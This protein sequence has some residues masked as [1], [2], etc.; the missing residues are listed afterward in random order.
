MLSLRE[1][2]NLLNAELIGD[3]QARFAAVNSDSRS[4]KSGDLFVA[5]PGEQFDGHDFI[6]KAVEQGASAVLAQRLPNGFKGNALL[7][8]DTY[9]ALAQLARAWRERFQLP[10]IA[11]TGSNGKTTVKEMIAAVLHAAYGCDAQ[12]QTAYLATPG[13]LNNHIGV[14]LT[15]L[16]L[17][18]THRAAVIE[19]GMNHPGEIA[20][21][22][23]L[24]QPTV[25]L[26]NNAQREHQE[27]MQSVAAVAQENGSVFGALPTDGVAVFP[28]N[29]EFDVLWR[30]LAAP[31]RCVTF[32]LQKSSAQL[33]PNT[34]G[35]HN[36]RNAEAAAACC[37]AIGINEATI[38]QGLASFTPVKGRL[39][40]QR[41]ANGSTLIDDSY[42]ANPD[43]VRAA[44]DV[45]ASCIAPTALV[46]GDMGEV[47]EDNSAAFHTEV[48]AY[49]KQRGIHYL[50]ALGSAMSASCTAFGA[51]AQHFASVETLVKVLRALPVTTVLV[52]GSR[53]MRMERV[54]QGLSEN[55]V[56]TQSTH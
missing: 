4:L 21:L 49:A 46:L 54:V 39:V 34:L 37:R 6:Q 26:V 40:V 31:R 32:Q 36:A 25:A 7:V 3:G 1:A 11:V 23:Q 55:F 8:P 17:R 38:A 19:L 16:K 51:G 52:K 47:G 18:D 2:A 53:F 56:S 28:A 13:N 42:N 43:S 35:E 10:V 14:P 5:L 24:A 12:G 50:L 30:E 29:T 22:A 33:V 41:L 48:G 44:I 45:L 27:F 9:Q 15:L 20:Q